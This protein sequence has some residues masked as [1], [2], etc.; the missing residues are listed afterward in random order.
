MRFSS[1]ATLLL[2]VWPCSGVESVLTDGDG[3]FNDGPSMAR[4]V[5]RRQFLSHQVS[6]DA[7]FE[8]DPRGGRAIRVPRPREAI[9]DAIPASPWR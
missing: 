7:H 8:E 3:R 5:R 6:V 4:A 2:A 1:I 9:L